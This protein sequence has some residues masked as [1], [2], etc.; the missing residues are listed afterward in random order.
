MINRKPPFWSVIAIGVAAA[1]V[2]VGGASTVFALD[3]TTAANPPQVSETGAVTTPS[4]STTSSSTPLLFPTPSLV[5]TPTPSPGDLTPHLTPTPLAGP[6]TEVVPSG[7]STQAPVAAARPTGITIPSLSINGGLLEYTVSEA[8]AQNC[9]SGG[10]ITCI[11]P[12]GLYSAYY[13]MQGVGGLPFGALPGTDAKANV[14]IAGHGGLTSGGS[15]TIFNKL[16]QIQPGADIAI[17]TGNGTIHYTVQRV[18]SVGKNS[19]YSV[20][21]ML[22]QRAGRLIIVTC[23]WSGDASV[24]GGH[25]TNNVVIV[26]QLA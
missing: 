22:S 18:V 20:P 1:V 6:D 7:G 25:S 8:K 5:A 10:Q 9:Y 11:D 2:G 17:A 16:Y 23:D 14:V 26:A 12:A 15:A 13:L 3:N 19:L 4:A 24:N 21:E